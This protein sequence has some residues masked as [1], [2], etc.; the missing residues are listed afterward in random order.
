MMDTITVSKEELINTLE[1][2]RAEHREIFEK[3]QAVYREKVIAELDRALDD[4]KNG[5]RIIRFINLPEPED[6]TNDFTTAI[7]MLSWHQG[8]QVDLDRR[9]FKRYVQNRWEW[10]SSFAANTQSYSA[11]L[12]EA[13]ENNS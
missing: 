4:A 6:H 2:N 1:G 5:R 12:D 9:D 3:A 10:D 7:E 11:M 13:E 8:D